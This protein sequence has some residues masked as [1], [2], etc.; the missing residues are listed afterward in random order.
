MQRNAV[1]TVQGP[2]LV[3]AGAG[4]GKT[5]VLVR[6]I[7]HILKYGNAYTCNTAPEDLTEP[8]LKACEQA[9]K[10]DHDALGEFLLRFSE[11][12]CPPWAVLAITFT[13]KA[14]KRN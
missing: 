11:D 5:T 3:L 8:L 7:V 14:A 2:L 13:N 6:R 9:K 12:F 10:L 4:S 1:C